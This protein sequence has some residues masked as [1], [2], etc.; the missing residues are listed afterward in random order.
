MKSYSLIAAIDKNNGIGIGN[1]LPWRLP[2]DMRHFKEITTGD[3][4]NAVIM[5]R[6]TWDSLAPYKPLKNRYNIVLS[7]KY[8]DQSASSNL[9]RPGPEKTFLLK[10]YSG[11]RGGG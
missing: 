2:P 3:G 8:F 4:H 5:G 1:K 11:F 10:V 7:R 9:K 6:K